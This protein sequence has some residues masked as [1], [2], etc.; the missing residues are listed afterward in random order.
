MI[1]AQLTKEDK[2]GPT[3]EHVGGM[4]SYSTAIYD[5]LD[6]LKLPPVAASIA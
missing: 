3:V 1:H 6:V 4:Y 5:I 2:Y